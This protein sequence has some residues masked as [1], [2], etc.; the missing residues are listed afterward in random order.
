ME[1]DNTVELIEL[2][3]KTF[4]L[5]KGEM[6]FTKDLIHLSVLQIHTLIYLKQN[7]KVTMS[8][9][10]EHFHIELSSATS[11]LNILC[12][13][14]LVKRYEDEKDRRLVI[15]ALTDKGKT[16]L[17]QVMGERK[18]KIEKILL[19]LSKKERNE[20]YNILLGLNTRL[21]KIK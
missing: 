9:V 20:L 15:V 11:L 10:A 7:D 12:D 4:R 5:M 18:E 19:Y 17:K 13:Q 8:N 1:Q 2:M 14:K 16:L 21:Q 3:F 6:S